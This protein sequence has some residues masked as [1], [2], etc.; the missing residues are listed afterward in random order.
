MTHTVLFVRHIE[1]VVSSPILPARESGTSVLEPTTESS[2]SRHAFGRSAWRF[3]P[4]GG[5]LRSGGPTAVCSA[6]HSRS[7][8]R[9]HRQ[10]AQE[11]DPASAPK[12]PRPGSSDQRLGGSSIGEATG[13][14]SPSWLE[15][16]LNVNWR[17]N[18]NLSRIVSPHKRWPKRTTSW[19]RQRTRLS[20]HR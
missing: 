17:C 16:G 3:H 14:G 6:V 20:G 9:L 2:R 7:Q 15:L 18:C 19:C 1:P 5:S 4:P 13:R 8:R 10:A 11:L 12:G